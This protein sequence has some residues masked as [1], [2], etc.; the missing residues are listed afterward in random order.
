MTIADIST[1]ALYVY[2]RTPLSIATNNVADWRIDSSSI[3]R[4]RYRDWETKKKEED[5]ENTMMVS[6]ESIQKIE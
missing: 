4:L 2:F 5:L 3:A 6:F 1:G